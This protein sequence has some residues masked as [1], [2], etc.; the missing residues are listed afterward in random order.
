MINDR[1]YNSLKTTNEVYYDNNFEIVNI[2][3]RVIFTSDG[4]TQ[5]MSQ[6]LPVDEW[7]REPR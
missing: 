6:V 7:I 5:L 4:T 1:T 3:K 2:N